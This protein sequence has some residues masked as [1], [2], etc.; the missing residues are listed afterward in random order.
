MKK[1]YA[2]VV[3]CAAYLAMSLHYIISTPWD[4][5][6]FLLCCTTSAIV[7]LFPGFVVERVR[8]AEI[9]KDGAQ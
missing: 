1:V 7:L 9:E 8:A 6:S 2:H 3:L 5:N 4:G